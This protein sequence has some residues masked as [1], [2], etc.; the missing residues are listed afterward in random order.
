MRT[1]LCLLLTTTIG[2]GASRALRGSPDTWVGLPTADPEATFVEALCPGESATNTPPSSQ[3]FRMKSGAIWDWSGADAP[4]FHRY[5]SNQWRY[6]SG[7]P[8]IAR[9]M[10]L[11]DATPTSGGT[12]HYFVEDFGG[13]AKVGHL[14]L[15]PDDGP[16][17][18]RILL[19]KKTKL[20][21]NGAVY[22]VQPIPH[23]IPV[24]AA[25]CYDRAPNAWPAPT[26]PATPDI[27]FHADKEL[28]DR[29]RSADKA[30]AGAIWV[31]SGL[32][33]MWRYADDDLKSTLNSWKYATDT[34]TKADLWTAIQKKYDALVAAGKAPPLPEA[35]PAAD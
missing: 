12:A 17:A 23:S 34:A 15:V 24:G 27:A 33:W 19:S 26:S 29:L 21:K 10:V 25:Y 11:V 14:L 20:K 4:Y 31:S 28:Q 30:E 7:D 16:Q 35:Q 8:G 18:Y 3:L 2:C 6:K 1:A 22:E 32:P 13:R 9:W 5:P